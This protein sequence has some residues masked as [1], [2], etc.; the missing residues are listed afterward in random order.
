MLF[1]IYVNRSETYQ[2]L[3]NFMNIRFCPSLD[4]TFSSYF[5]S[6][7]QTVYTSLMFTIPQWNQT[8]CVDFYANIFSPKC[9]SYV[10]NNGKYECE[11]CN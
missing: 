6:S 2:C 4:Y 8:I 5:C 10:L 3:E 7:S 1:R 11:C 9:G